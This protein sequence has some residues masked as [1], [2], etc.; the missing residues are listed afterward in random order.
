MAITG[1]SGGVGSRSISWSDNQVVKYQ[2]TAAGNM[3]FSDISLPAGG[4]YQKKE[5]YVEGGTGSTATF[6]AYWTEEAGGDALTFPS[7]N[8][9]IVTCFQSTGGSEEFYYRVENIS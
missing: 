9:I 7:F 6:P 2:I 3:T 1:G 8:R 4:V 5:F